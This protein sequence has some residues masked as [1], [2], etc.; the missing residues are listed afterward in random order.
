MVAERSATIRQEANAKTMGIVPEEKLDRTTSGSS[1]VDEEH[2][3]VELESEPVC[4]T[5]RDV[6][7]DEAMQ[8]WT[9]A[10]FGVWDLEKIVFCGR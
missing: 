5:E 1:S 4:W 9:L 6:K 2:V 8:K 10:G 3:E 7:V